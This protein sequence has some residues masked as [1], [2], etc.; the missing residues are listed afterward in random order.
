MTLSI[1]PY[2]PAS[3]SAK[4]LA[5]NLGIKRIKKQGSN[6]RGNPDKVVINWGNSM[7]DNPEISKCQVINKPEAVALAADKLKCFNSLEAFGVRIP[8]FTTDRNIAWDWLVEG[9]EIVCRTILNGHSGE[10]IVLASTTEQLVDAPLYVRYIPKKQEYRVHVFKGRTVDVQ[11]KARNKDVPDDKVDWKI[12]NHGNGFVFCRNEHLG[13]VPRDVTVQA[14]HAIVALGL[15]FGAV[16]VIY[17]DKY[18]RAYVLEVNT[19]PGLTGE[20]LEKYT[21]LF[22]TYYGIVTKKY[23]KVVMNELLEAMWN[24]RAAVANN[25]QPVQ[26]PPPQPV[27][28]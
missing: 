8:S 9:N 13:D 15:D 2:N 17:N 28:W 21:K 16:D 23:S 14:E 3:E 26:V 18:N 5:E 11:R 1:F 20:T 10:G 27:E 19:A 24:Q 7:I 22:E 12:R 4:G 25:D 6:F